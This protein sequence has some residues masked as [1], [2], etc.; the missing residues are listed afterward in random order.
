MSERSLR[1][2]TLGS[3]VLLC[4]I[5]PTVRAEDLV[6][7]IQLPQ[8]WKLRDQTY[9]DLNADGLEDL[10]LSVGHRDTEFKRALRIHYQRTTP[11]YFAM[12]PD[13][14]V[15]LTPDVIAYALADVDSNPGR[16]VLL[17]TAAA[18]FGTRLSSPSGE[19]LFKL[20]DCDLLWQLPNKDTAFSWQDAVLD[21]NGDGRED[22]FWPQSGGFRVLLQSDDGLRV[23][24][25]RATPRVQN[26]DTRAPGE[27]RVSVDFKDL[28]TTFG[29]AAQ[30]GP[31]VEAFH[32][33]RVPLFRDFD[34]DGCLDLLTQT[35]K[36]LSLWRQNAGDPLFPEGPATLTLPLEEGADAS[37]VSATHH[38]LVDLNN[39]GRCDFVL[40]S[41]VR[42]SKQLS[43]QL[44]IYLNEPAAD[45]TE[46]LFGSDGMPDGFMKL[47]GLPGTLQV[48]DINGDG[49]PDLSLPVIRFDLLDKVKTVTSRSL[50]FQW[51]VFLNQQGRFNRQP[52]LMQDMTLSIEDQS[53]GALGRFVTDYNGDGLLDVLVRVS[54]SRLGLRL[55]RRTKTGLSLAEPLAWEMAVDPEAKVILTGPGDDPVL[56][57]VQSDQIMQVRFK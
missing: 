25:W 56:L 4:L 17:L 16:E 55:L 22:V 36:E 8:E 31:L 38:A 53:D 1:S 42:H 29:L 45:E 49:Y 48:V 6:A 5:I 46:A 32:S 18:C 33:C 50:D 2:I 19:R 7:L 26:E 14:V 34:G 44:L 27:I 15:T 51:L 35:P 30:P 57:I 41:R 23:T 21:I 52:D 3:L 43:A 28:G 54:E 12:E 13:E 20:A 10:V 37:V 24:D 9:G 11:P 40:V 47:A 39:D